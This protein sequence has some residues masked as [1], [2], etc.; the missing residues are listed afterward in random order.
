VPWSGSR[1]DLTALIGTAAF[2]RTRVCDDVANWGGLPIVL[3]HTRGEDDEPYLREWALWAVRNMT[4]ASDM[5]RNK[6]SELQPQAIEESEDLLSRGLG[7]ELNRETGKPRV[8]KREAPNAAVDAVQP[9]EQGE[10]PEFAIPENW[11]ITEL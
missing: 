9:E 2:K 1:V 4:Q 11:K 6:I 7:V 5:A 10:Q 8:V 3:N